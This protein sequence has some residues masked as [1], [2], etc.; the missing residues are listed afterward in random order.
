[1][2]FDLPGGRVAV[3]YDAY[4][5]HPDPDDD[6]AKTSDIL[7][8]G[9]ADLV[10]RIRERPLPTLSEL[11]VSVP[12]RPDPQLC[13][14]ILVR[15]L[16]HLTGGSLFDYSD[17]R[18]RYSLIPRLDF[19]YRLEHEYVAKNGYVGFDGCWECLAGLH[20]CHNS[21]EPADLSLVQEMLGDDWI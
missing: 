7:A 20:D 11:D 5:F 3:E 6:T 9:Q 4:Y 18:A 1:M 19:A 8:S 16:Q 14:L 10:V 21:S 13:A 2:I 12:T 17:P 15:H